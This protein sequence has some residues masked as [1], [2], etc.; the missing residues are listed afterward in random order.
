[1]KTTSKVGARIL[2][3]AGRLFY[4]QGYQSTGINQIIA[5]S[6]VAKAS[7]YSHY[8]TKEHLCI[9]YLSALSDAWFVTLEHKVKNKK[10]EKTRIS[11]L[12][13]HIIAFHTEENF[14]GC[15]FLNV[16]AEVG[17]SSSTITEEIARHK[18][19]LLTYF[20]Q[21]IA[22]DK[23]AARI[24]ILYEAALME[25]Q[26]FADTWPAKQAKELALEIINSQH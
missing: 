8:P 6:E 20:K 7:F 18:T 24:Y 4:R 23:K 2:E 5:E 9:S 14:R 16:R 10:S 21:L 22:D 25:C 19:K 1:M 26:V 17:Q 11:A 3:T 13:D 12:F 15:A